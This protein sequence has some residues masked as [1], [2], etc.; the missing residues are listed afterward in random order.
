MNE[1]EQ[2]FDEQKFDEQKF[3]DDCYKMA[4]PAVIAVGKCT[5]GDRELK[6]V[7]RIASEI[8]NTSL[9]FR[10]VREA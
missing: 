5:E 8:A 10:R 9:A 7:C 1:E 2:K 6:F 3:W 4:L